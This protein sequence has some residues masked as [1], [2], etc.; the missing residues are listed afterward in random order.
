M[1]IKNLRT[2]EM[3]KSPTIMADVIFEDNSCP[4]MT[5]HYQTSREY[6]DGFTLNPNVF[7]LACSLPAMRG[8]EKRIKMDAE[9]CPVLIEGVTVAINCLIGSYKGSRILPTFEVNVAKNKQ[10]K[11][12]ERAGSFLSG[13]V[14]SMATLRHNRQLYADTHPASFKDSFYI[15]GSADIGVGHRDERDVYERGYRNLEEIAGE[16]GLSIIPVYTN[17]RDLALLFPLD[18][19]VLV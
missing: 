6:E 7:F 19:Y 18:F 17:V 5:I 13:G 12:P 4:N 16:V 15:Y 11:L 8:S 3:N 2:E 10:F 14:D 9:V 1:I